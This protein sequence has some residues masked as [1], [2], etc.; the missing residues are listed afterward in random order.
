MNLIPKFLP[1]RCDNCCVG[2]AKLHNGFGGIN[3]KWY[4]CSGNANANKY[5]FNSN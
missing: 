2:M 3:E 4:I 1:F 5:F